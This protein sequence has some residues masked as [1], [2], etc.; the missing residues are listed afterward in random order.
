MHGEQGRE[1][2]TPLTT[3]DILPTLLGL[4]GVGVPATIEGEDLSAPIRE[5]RELADR[6]V[7]YMGVAPFMPREF[8][9]EYRAVRTSRYTYVRSLEGP[10]M[11]FDDEQDPYQMDNLVGKPAHAVL[12]QQLDARLQAELQ[13]I[14]DNFRPGPS[15][16][17]EWGYQIGA[18]GS[19]PYNEPD[20]KPQTPRRGSK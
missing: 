6:V 12:A 10:W 2:S 7:L 16:V 11:L 8:A 17:A 20:A 14:G 3:P 15:Y 13:R 5:V 18:H 9:Q 1:V 4:A 19:V